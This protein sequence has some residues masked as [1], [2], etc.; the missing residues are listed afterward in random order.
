MYA[1]SFAGGTR[2]S[3][4]MAVKATAAMVDD[5]PVAIYKDPK[6]D[7]GS[8]KSAKGFLVVEHN[9]NGE[10]VLRD[11]VEYINENV[12]LLRTVFLNGLTPYLQ[13]FQEVRELANKGK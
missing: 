4:G 10:I 13:T 2:D 1:Y 11:Q 8:K 9:E 12:G 5:Q 3:L 7:N 6:T